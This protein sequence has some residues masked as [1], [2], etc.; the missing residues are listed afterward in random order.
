MVRRDDD[1]ETVRERSVFDWNVEF[2]QNFPP[3]IILARA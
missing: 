1:A 2:L 3:W